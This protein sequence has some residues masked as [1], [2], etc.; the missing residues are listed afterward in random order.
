MITELAPAKVNLTLRVGAVGPE[1]YHPV[2]SI[3]VF[4]D[5]GDRL[6]VGPSDNLSLSI[7]GPQAAGVPT[8]SE[9]LVLKA[10]DALARATGQAPVG[11]IAL[12]KNIPTGAGIGGGSADAAAALRAFNRLWS[13]DWPP[14]MLAGIAAEIGSDV[15]ACVWSRP[16]RMSGRGERIR[17][18]EGWPEFPAV[19]VNPG[20]SVA[21]GPVFRAF[22][23]DEC[24]TGAPFRPPSRLDR[25]GILAALAAASNDLTGPACKTAPVIADILSALAAFPGSGIARMSGSGATC[26]ALF[27]TTD[28]RDDAAGRLRADHPD[29]HVFPVA[30][31]GNPSITPA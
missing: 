8:D 19:L 31:Q 9:N 18:I 26:F 17:L 30:L 4:A 21:T 23:D 14:D 12:A 16:L 3:V 27:D 25:D 7:D 6:T 28:L 2:D 13:L 15:P 29:W 11:S 10:V 20:I 1:G 5:W 22:D 24:G